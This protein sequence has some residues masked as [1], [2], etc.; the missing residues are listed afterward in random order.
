MSAA[1]PMVT[2]FW[3]APASLRV[4][5]FMPRA[6]CALTRRACMP[7]HLYRFGTVP[8]AFPRSTPS[9]LLPSSATADEPGMR[10]FRRCPVA[11]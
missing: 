10:V 6:V 7:R 9:A 11:A 4:S 5:C 8:I 3:C 2:T 1:I